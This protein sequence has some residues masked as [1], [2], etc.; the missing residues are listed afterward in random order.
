MAV[1]EIPPTMDAQTAWERRTAY[2]EMEWG[3]WKSRFDGMQKIVDV[4]LALAKSDEEDLAS[5]LALYDHPTHNAKG[6]PD[7]NYH[8]APDL[9]EIDVD[10][11]KH[12]KLTPQELWHSR[13]Q[14]QDFSLTTFRG[15]LHQEIQ[16][17]K[18][19]SQWVD[20]KKDY[21]LVNPPSD[22]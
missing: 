8:E 14:Y 18:W 3:T 13:L 9:L 20:G 22:D 7:W 16:T 10:D 6:E 19:R 2:K 1:G 17:R 5:D 15:H 4:K 21:A 11:G 12:K